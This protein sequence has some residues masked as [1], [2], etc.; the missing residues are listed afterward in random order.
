M[1]GFGA[2]LIII[3]CA[4]IAQSRDFGLRQLGVVIAA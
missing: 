1:A 3:V 4:K 2:P